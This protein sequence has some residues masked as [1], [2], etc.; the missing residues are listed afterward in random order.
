M[1]EAVDPGEDDGILL[2][3]RPRARSQAQRASRGASL[4]V[5]F[6]G[7]TKRGQ[8]RDIDSAKALLAEYKARKKAPAPNAGPQPG[9]R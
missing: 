9:K 4:I 8:Q 5:L 3:Q 1:L 6:G 2:V 7:G